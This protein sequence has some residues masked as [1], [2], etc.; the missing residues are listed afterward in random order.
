MALSIPTSFN[1]DIQG[2]DTNLIPVVVIGKWIKEQ[3]GQ[4][5]LSISIDPD[6][7]S[8][9]GGINGIYLSTSA[10][11]INVLTQITIPPS[12]APQVWS[13]DHINFKPILLNIPSLKESISIEKRNYKISNVTLDISNYEYEG[14]R[15]SELIG[16]L[17]LINLECRIFWV[18]PSS[19]LIVPVDL[20]HKYTDTNGDVLEPEAWT[21]DPREFDID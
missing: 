17:P 3:P 13:I 14:K 18:S 20:Q 2:Q 10:I 15:F 16:H 21:G 11:N 9:F 5:W 12:P 4:D 7:Y 19:K 8:E 1:I 6:D